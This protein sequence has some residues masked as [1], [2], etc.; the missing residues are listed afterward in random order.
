LLRP[1]RPLAAAV[2]GPGGE[3][4]LLFRHQ[5]VIEV[6]LARRHRMRHVV[7]REDLHLEADPPEIVV[8][9]TAHSV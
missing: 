7:T 8:G 6:P 5:Q 9:A 1:D 3:Q 2:H 4:V